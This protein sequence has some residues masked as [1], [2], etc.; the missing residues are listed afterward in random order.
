MSGALACKLFATDLDGTVLIDEG[1]AGC[2]STPRLKTA[3]RALE[4]RGTVICLASGRMHESIRVIGADL[5]VAG[6]VISYN[7]AMLR[8]HGDEMLSHHTL[9]PEVA[10]D[11]VDLAEER[12][13][14]LNFYCDG[15][16]YARKIQPW[17]DL[18]HGRTSS[19][20]RPMESLKPMAGRRPT[21]LLFYAPAPDI[22]SLREELTPRLAGKA[23]L[24][25]T[26]NEYLEV[27]PL[28]ADK[29]HALADL[30]SRLGL[31]AGDVVAA[32]DGYNDI[33]MISFA[34]TGIAIANGRQA[35]KDRADS[36]VAAPEHDGLA[37]YIEQHLL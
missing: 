28:E 13:L 25:I 7:G 20:M 5:G 10:A 24:L 9:D 37:Q 6:P 3:L 29:G 30:T 2:R 14:P 32:G 27:M 23:T 35:L 16:L 18:Y 26:A 19:P 12:G 21:K 11:M 1:P 17:W 31:R 36:V 34:G 33:G 15:I 4:A 8:D 22:L